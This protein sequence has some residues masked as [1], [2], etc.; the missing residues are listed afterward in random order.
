MYIKE[1]VIDGFKS[2]AQQTTVG[3]F[4]PHFNAITGLNGSGKSNIL[5]SICF[6]LG[7]SNLTQVR[8]THL[9]ELIYKGG[10]AGVTKATVSITFDNMDKSQSPIGYQDY[11][12]IT[13]TRQIS[14]GNKH[15]YLINGQN[16]TAQ[17]VSDLFCSVQLN[18]NNPNFL[19]MQGKITKVLNMKPVEILSMIEEAAGTK[20]YDVKKENALQ[21][22]EKKNAKLN[23]IERVLREDITPVIEKL[24]HERAAYIEYQKCER[25][26]KHL[27]KFTQAY[28]YYQNEQIVNKNKLETNEIEADFELKKKRIEEI[29]QSVENMKKEIAEHMRNMKDCENNEALQQIEAELKQ[30]RIDVAK[31]NSDLNHLKSNTTGDTKRISQ[32]QKSIKEVN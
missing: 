15:K 30:N 22:I 7:I 28:Q 4:D 2:Y 3:Q 32:I 1:I 24:E 10:N 27:H 14:V 29:N 6:V 25:E 5:D 9:Q 26:F 12:E 19:I 18:V 11:E 21:T 16:A 8:A 13:I 17:R 20:T 31:L 23:E